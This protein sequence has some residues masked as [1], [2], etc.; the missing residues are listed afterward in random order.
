M[1]KEEKKKDHAEGIEPTEE[2]AARTKKAKD[3]LAPVGERKK[4]KV[5]GPTVTVGKIYTLKGAAK[6]AMDDDK[7]EKAEAKS[8]EENTK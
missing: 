8:K 7:K 1:G 6:E 5:G 4:P 3:N 2:F